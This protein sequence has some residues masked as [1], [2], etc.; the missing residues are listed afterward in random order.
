VTLGIQ[1]VFWRDSTT[2]SLGRES[3][4]ASEKL[5]IIKCAEV[6]GNRAAGGQFD[7]D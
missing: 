6:R 7:G 5:T 2:M 3:Y 4:T 1:Q